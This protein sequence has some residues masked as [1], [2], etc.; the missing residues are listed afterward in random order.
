MQYNLEGKE[1]I[2]TK[3]RFIYVLFEIVF[4]TKYIDY[5][6]D[7]LNSDFYSYRIYF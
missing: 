2:I 5:F 7:I 3:N 1:K 4:I 6:F